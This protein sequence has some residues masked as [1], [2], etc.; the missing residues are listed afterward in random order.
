MC[1]KGFPALA[2]IL[3]NAV[4]GNDTCNGRLAITTQND[5]YTNLADCL[6]ADDVAEMQFGAPGEAAGSLPAQSDNTTA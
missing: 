4:P 1:V 3:Y 5:P 6:H 2:G